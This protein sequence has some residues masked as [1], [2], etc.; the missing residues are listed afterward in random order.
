MKPFIKENI[1]KLITSESNDGMSSYNNWMAQQHHNAYEVFYNFLNEVKPKRILEIGTARGGFTQFLS[2]VSKENNLD[3]HIL[4]Y[5][6]FVYRDANWFEEMA[7]NNVDLRIENVFSNDYTEVKQEVI[8]YIQQDGT[9]IVLCDGAEKIKE[10]NLLS[11]YLKPGDYILAHDYAETRELFENE[12]QNKLWN[13]NEINQEQI[14][15]SC[16]KNN[17]EKYNAD[18]F[19]SVV[20]TCRVKKSLPTQK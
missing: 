16:L 5:D 12:I 19:E 11:N 14:V 10:F 6:I 15:N 9:T 1:T 2:W 20:W 17:L 18:V 13:W 8:D 7:N 4:S 3:I